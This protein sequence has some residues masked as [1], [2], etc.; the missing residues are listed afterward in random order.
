MT[1]GTC[2]VCRAPGHPFCAR[3]LLAPSGRRGGWLSA[4]QRKLGMSG[5]ETLTIDA[6]NVLK[7]LWVGSKPPVDRRLPMFSMIVLAA[8]EVQPDRH[9]WD[10]RVVR[11]RLDDAEPTQREITEAVLAAREVADELRRGGRV[12]VTCHAGLNRSAWV[13]AMAMLIVKPKATPSAVIGRIRQRRG[14]DA[15]SNPHFVAS[16][17][18]LFSLRQSTQ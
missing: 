3:H 11:A 12:L 17:R 2:I 16:L 13:A 8:K 1:L 4:H 14:P 10:A 7:G 9:P 15:L 5:H 6:H 18:R